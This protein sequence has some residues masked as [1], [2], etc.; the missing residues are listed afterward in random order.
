MDR[1]I[2][3]K[4][5]SVKKISFIIIGL[6][7][8]LVFIWFFIFRDNSKIYYV[9]KD[10][11]EISKVILQDFIEYI[12]IDG[13]VHPKNSINIDAVRG[14]IVQDIFV[15]DGMY[16]NENAVIVK[17]QNADMEIRFM[18]QE[19]RIYDAINNL[20]STQ[21]NLERN[22]FTR[23]KEIVSLLYSIDKLKTDFDRK[24]TLFNK[25]VIA[26]QEFEDIQRRY[27]ESKEQ[28]ELSLKLAQLDSVSY[29]QRNNHIT[30]SIKRMN[31]NLK[32]LSKNFDKLYIKTPE[33]GKL[34]SFQLELGQTVIPGQRLGQIDMEGGSLLKVNIDERYTARVYNG[35]KAE[36]LYNDTVFYLTILKV[37]TSINN[38]V[39]QVDMAFVGN[40]PMHIKRGQTLQLRLLF[41]SPE[42]VIVLKKGGFFQE[43]G[44]NWIFVLNRSGEFAIKRKI[45]IGRQN[46]EFYE[47]I[48]GLESNERVIISS[49]NQFGGKNKLILNK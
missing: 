35:Q 29:D 9:E 44:G 49:Y 12:P 41:S 15:E 5:W 46:S 24:Q 10:Q 8:M 33:Q 27:K 22:K 39:F 11:I 7:L 28:L 45:E 16:L 43:T 32:L 13:V 20:Q 40:E 18:E 42:K 2:S 6:L 1:N 26:L 25:D 31:D 23:Q 21:L 34:S 17:L 47:V 4:Y 3:S 30:F 14:G 37:Y 38:G 36:Y 48:N 19:T